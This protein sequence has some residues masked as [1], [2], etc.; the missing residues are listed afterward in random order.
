MM[1]FISD[2]LMQVGQAIG[3][4][5]RTWLYL[6]MDSGHAMAAP[7]YFPSTSQVQIGDW[8]DAMVV[9]DFDP[10]R[11]TTVEPVALVIKAF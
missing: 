2:N 8:I 11:R 10:D 4:K 7:G 1:A 6:T 5:L 9:D 3:G